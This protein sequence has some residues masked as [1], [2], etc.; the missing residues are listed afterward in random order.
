M[1]EGPVAVH[2]GL[3]SI[4][5]A[6]PSLKRYFDLVAKRPLIVAAGSGHEALQA[7]GIVPHVCAVLDPMPIMADFIR[8]PHQDTHYYVASHCDPAV[9]HVLRDNRVT[10]WNAAIGIEFPGKANAFR[11]GGGSTVTLRCWNLG[12]VLGY[13]SFEF[14]GFDACLMDGERHMLPDWNSLAAYDEDARPVV[15]HGKEFVSTNN[16]IAMACEY[17]E[18]SKLYGHLYKVAVHGD[19]LIS[20]ITHRGQNECPKSA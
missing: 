3:F 2:E 16:L 15:A 9:F 5:G 7:A 12:M 11:I 4:V 18:M 10:V 20:W 17:I 6:G 1:L 19:G 14:F 8:N 13:R